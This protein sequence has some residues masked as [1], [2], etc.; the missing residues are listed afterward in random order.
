MT[1]SVTLLSAR[2]PSSS[3]HTKPSPRSVPVLA[4]IYGAAMNPAWLAE[5]GIRAEP[6]TLAR[7]PDHRLSFHGYTQVWDGAEEAALPAP[8]QALW[9]VIYKVSGLDVD[10]LD[11][12]Q[13]VRLNGTGTYFHYPVE[14]IDAEGA[15]HTAVMYRKAALRDERP[16]STEYLAYVVE[17]AKACGLPAD[18]VEAVSAIASVPAAYPVPLKANSGAQTA[19][20]DC[21]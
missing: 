15:V 5:R 18:Y 21:C 19:E 3:K 20:S 16:P 12:A 17:G 11:A 7:L 8:G 4:F 10:R 6:V 1:S 9:G 14:V 13:G 2:P